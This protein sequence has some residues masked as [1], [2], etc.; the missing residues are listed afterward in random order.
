MYFSN[1]VAKL[2]S[3]VKKRLTKWWN[4]TSKK[5]VF[6]DCPSADKPNLTFIV[7]KHP[8]GY[9]LPC[10]GKTK[11]SKDSS[12]KKD[13]IYESCMTDHVYVDNKMG[14][15]ESKYI[16]SYGKS[17][18][19]D[20]LIN[21]ISSKF[22]KIF[23]SVHVPSTKTENYYAIGVDNK[24]S[25]FVQSILL[26]L[27]MTNKQFVEKVKE[28]FNQDVN[29]TLFYKLLNGNIINYIR[30]VADL[31]THLHNGTMHNNLLYEDL[32][33]Y[34]F[35]I[36]VIKIFDHDTTVEF[37]LKY[38]KSFTVSRYMIFIKT[39]ENTYIP[40]CSLVPSEYFKDK[41]I[42]ERIFAYSDSAVGKVM[43]LL[44]KH[45]MKN[46]EDNAKIEK[47]E[48][49]VAKTGKYKIRRGLYNNNQY[50]IMVEIVNIN[51][52]VAGEF[53]I[54]IEPVK[55]DVFKY[56]VDHIMT[57]QRGHVIDKEAL[58]D[59]LKLSGNG[60]T[61]KP[62]YVKYDTFKVPLNNIFDSSYGNPFYINYVVCK[63]PLTALPTDEYE[64]NLDK[65]FDFIGDVKRLYEGNIISK[66]ITLVD[67]EKI[68]DAKALVKSTIENKKYV[69]V[70]ISLLRDKV[71][72][73]YIQ[74]NFKD[75]LLAFTIQPH[76][77]IN[78]K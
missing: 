67:E 31:F 18:E 53:Y 59:F 3:N 5:E 29:A 40:V 21:V 4:F 46:D 30:D 73:S 16:F 56:P 39:T 45:N 10:C 61:L 51:V 7:G 58:L 75:K 74:Y 64:K 38:Y 77:R 9:C 36:R 24:T 63:Q 44:E 52:G 34:I 50:I 76:E 1:E 78:I 2:P 57:L 54:P 42:R 43:I 35:D 41:S 15:E 11:F 72:R 6:Y 20:R 37:K 48:N 65:S 60:Y 68:K 8:L 49:L 23:S 33:F 62:R 66:V 69:D 22:N 26:C 71:F 32:L 47:F 27:G 28:G 19:A 70:I 17:F 12:Y 13:K 25:T 55:L 14:N